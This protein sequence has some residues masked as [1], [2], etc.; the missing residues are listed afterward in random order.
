MMQDMPSSARSSSQRLAA[1]PAE[2][3]EAGQGRCGGKKEALKQTLAGIG[4][5]CNRTRCYV[6]DKVKP[7][8]LRFCLHTHRVWIEHP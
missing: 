8:A 3:H 6:A 7:S 5:L 4:N 2:A 1:L